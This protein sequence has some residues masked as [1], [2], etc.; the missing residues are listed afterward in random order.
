MPKE[1]YVWPPWRVDYLEALYR[2]V[3]AETG[4]PYEPYGY[5]DPKTVGR[6][7]WARGYA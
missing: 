2:I 1:A 7:L 4:T 6:I 5:P 3:Q